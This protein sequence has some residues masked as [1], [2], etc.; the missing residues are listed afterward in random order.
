MT[1]SLE[2]NRVGIGVKGV[3]LHFWGLC[4][5][6]VPIWELFLLIALLMNFGR[7]SLVR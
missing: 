4:V 5:T 2:L 3:N 1:G 6:S 7:G